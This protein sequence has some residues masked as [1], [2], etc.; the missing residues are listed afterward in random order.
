MSEKQTPGQSGHLF[1]FFQ[2]PVVQVGEYYVFTLKPDHELP[3]G[4]TRADFCDSPSVPSVSAIP[5][6]E[7]DERAAKRLK[8]GLR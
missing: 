2:I 7:E 4:V 8:S 3:D 6:T 5:V 1:E